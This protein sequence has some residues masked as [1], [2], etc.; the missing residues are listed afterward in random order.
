MEAAVCVCKL[1][2]QA[3][4]TGYDRA[5]AAADSRRGRWVLFW[6][7]SGIKAKCAA[8]L[9]GTQGPG[10]LKDMDYSVQEEGLTLKATLRSLFQEEGSE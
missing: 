10:G 1:S 7:V 6:D 4:C 8:L 9:G 5:R 3:R 2:V